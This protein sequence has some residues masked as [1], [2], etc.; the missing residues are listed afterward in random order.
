MKTE[1]ISKQLAA[2]EAHMVSTGR[3]I[4]ISY[5]EGGGGIG[6]HYMVT[7]GE[8]PYCSGGTLL[9]AIT[10]FNS[11]HLRLKRER[12]QKELK[13]TYTHE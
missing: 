1:A 7:D 10:N 6:L 4:R 2:L 12:L 8:W 13:E 3:G 9:G 11:E 5:D